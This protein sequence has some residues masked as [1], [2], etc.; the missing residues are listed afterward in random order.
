MSASFCALIRQ[1]PAKPLIS[2]LD[3]ACQDVLSNSNQLSGFVD[4]PGWRST[5]TYVPDKRS[6]GLVTAYR[7]CA[8]RSAP[9]CQS[10]LF[11]GTD[12]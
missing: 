7:A 3:H 11:Q 12:F 9:R 5:W 6:S 2:L 4:S 1:E 10:Y 8:G